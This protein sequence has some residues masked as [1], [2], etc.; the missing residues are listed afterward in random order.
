MELKRGWL[1]PESSAQ[2]AAAVNEERRPKKETPGQVMVVVASTR[3]LTS[4]L[5]GGASVWPAQDDEHHLVVFPQ[6]CQFLRDRWR[7]KDVYYVVCGEMCLAL[8]IHLP[9]EGAFQW[10]LVLPPMHQVA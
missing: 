9:W 1:F 5:T 8:L 2:L 10:V 3:A 7:G 6:T 4:V